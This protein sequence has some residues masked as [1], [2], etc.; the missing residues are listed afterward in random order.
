[1]AAVR[2]RWSMV[3]A[4][5]VLAIVGGSCGSSLPSFNADCRGRSDCVP[6]V[7]IAGMNYIPTC[8]RAD[9]AAVGAVIAKGKLN[10]HQAEVRQLTSVDRSLALTIRA[11]GWCDS[12]GADDL[13]LESQDARSASAAPICAAVIPVDRSFAD[14]CSSTP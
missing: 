11:A 9:G 8:A 14:V 10:G 6:L 2:T 7:R 1:M 12:K 5:S 3:V 13:V 4:V